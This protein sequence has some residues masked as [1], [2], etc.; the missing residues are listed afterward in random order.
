MAIQWKTHAFPASRS[1]L[2]C[3]LLV[4]MV[5]GCSK[6]PQDWEAA[7]S[8]DTEASYE[9]YLAEHADG[10][11]AADA[12]A[13]LR[14]IRGD[15]AWQELSGNHSA[16]ALGAFVEAYPEHEAIDEARFLHRIHTQAEAFAAEDMK[17][18]GAEITG[19]ENGGVGFE[20]DEPLTQPG[21]GMVSTSMGLQSTADLVFDPDDLVAGTHVQLYMIFI[22]TEL[23]GMTIK[24]WTPVGFV[25]D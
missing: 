4:V 23:P 25:A 21:L 19:A 10:E 8:A 1:M 14:S 20:F 15:R 17:I 13:R 6:E 24:H 18:V 5:S 22:E 16:E 3:V 2:S 9:T 12:N 11:H 7:S